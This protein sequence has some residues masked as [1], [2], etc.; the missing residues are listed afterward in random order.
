MDYFSK[1]V[2][3]ES[4]A[5]ITEGAVLRFIWKNIV[6][7]FGLPRKLFSDNGSWVEEIPGVLW[8][9]RTT[10]RIA[11]GQTPFSLVYGS[12]AVLP[13]EIGQISSRVKAY[14]EGEIVARTQELDLIE[15]KMERASIR[16]KAYRYRIMKA[17]NQKIKPR[18][19]QIRVLVLKNVNPAEEVKNL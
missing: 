11:T 14:Q 3:A 10:P 15:E 18:E 8:A 6:C 4:L 16:M 17:F 13:I 19:F 1:W 9:Y 7:R 12:K 2:E 5:K